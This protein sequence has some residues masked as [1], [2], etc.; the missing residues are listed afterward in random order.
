M[1]RIDGPGATQDERFTE[2]NPAAAIPATTVTAD[3][4][5]AVQEEIAHVI[6]GAGNILDKANNAQ[7]LAAVQALIDA[8]MPTAF[9]TGDVKLTLATTA[10]AGW[11]MADDGTIGP[12]G[13]GATTRANDDTHDLYVLLWG[14]VADAWAPV[15]GGRGASA[16][17][18]WAAGKTMALPRMLGRA[19]AVAGAG[20]GLTARALGQ[21]LGEETHL[22]TEAEIPAHT[23]TLTLPRK[24]GSNEGSG[25]GFSKSN[26]TTSNGS[27]VTSAT[28]GDQPHNN[29]PP[30]A[31]LHAMIKL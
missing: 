18:D 14:G 1:H 29:M 28:G 24:Y 16:E 15:T 8:N 4:L 7:L 12:A 20:A 5:N 22:L 25:T 10:P 27:G 30:T 3:W 9:A 2:G 21:Y 6:E 17:D 11:V 13:S 19:L 26:G 31:F 23:H